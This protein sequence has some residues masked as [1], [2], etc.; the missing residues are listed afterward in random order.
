MFYVTTY[1]THFI[2]GYM[3][4]DIWKRTNTQQLTEETIAARVLLYTS[5][6]RKDSTY[7]RVCYTTDFDA[8]NM[9]HWLEQEIA[10]WV[11]HKGLIR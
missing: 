3:M 11:H 1:S 7:H 6:H 2:Y 9:E 8:P 10:Q 5:S 4:S